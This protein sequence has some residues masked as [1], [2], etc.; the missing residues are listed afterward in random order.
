MPVEF[1]V[2]ADG[3]MT[4]AGPIYGASGSAIP[5]AFVSVSIDG[6]KQS[7]TTN[8]TTAF[9]KTTKRYE[10]TIAGVRIARTQ[11]TALATMSGWNGKPLLINTDDSSNGKLLVD[12]RD[13]NGNLAQADFQVAIFKAH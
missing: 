13:L 7:G 11:H 2:E 10:I 9:N 4:A 5:L 1:T 6:T 3:T 12:L 8:V